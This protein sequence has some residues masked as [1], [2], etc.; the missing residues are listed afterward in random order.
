M[1]DELSKI[2]G[3]LSIEEEELSY[4]KGLSDRVMR[5]KNKSKMEQIS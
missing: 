5:R 1:I 4:E 2:S 3:L